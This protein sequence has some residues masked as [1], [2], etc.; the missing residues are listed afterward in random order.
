MFKAVYDIRNVLGR[1]GV[2]ADLM[3]QNDPDQRSSTG[4]KTRREF[5]KASTQ[6]KSGR[7]RFDQLMTKFGKFDLATVDRINTV[8]NTRSS[9]GSKRGRP[10]GSKNKPKA[11]AKRGRKSAKKSAK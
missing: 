2:A 1:I 5:R 6:Y 4:T 11:G 7:K 9:S 3:A 8:L 10:K